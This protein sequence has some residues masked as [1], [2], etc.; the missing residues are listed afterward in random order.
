MSSGPAPPSECYSSIALNGNNVTDHL[1][2]WL[3][4]QILQS[5]TLD[6]VSHLSMPG[7]L[8]LSNSRNCRAYL[9]SRCE[10]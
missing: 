8:C 9:T 5:A 7:L 4:A 3:G 10:F 1:A 6:E 2:Q